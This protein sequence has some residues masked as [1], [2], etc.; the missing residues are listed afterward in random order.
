MNLEKEMV[1]NDIC[2]LDIDVA[3]DIVK[4][5]AEEMCKKQRVIDWN[6]YQENW[7]TIEVANQIKNLDN[8]PLATEKK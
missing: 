2:D 1:D 4:Q 6:Y 8:A 5:Y 3:I 7:Y